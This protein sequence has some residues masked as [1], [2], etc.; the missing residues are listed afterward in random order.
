M[1]A[2]SAEEVQEVKVLEPGKIV[3]HVGRRYSCSGGR[4]STFCIFHRPPEECG[5]A[6]REL[7]DVVRNGLSC[8]ERPLGRTTGWVTY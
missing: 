7:L 2:N 1:E 8:G 3:L 6:R 5:D 4:Q